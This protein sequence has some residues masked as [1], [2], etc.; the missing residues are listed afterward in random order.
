[1][2]AVLFFLRLTIIWIIRIRIRTCALIAGLLF[3]VLLLFSL[4]L[5]DDGEKSGFIFLHI[6]DVGSC[7]PNS[8]MEILLSQAI[9]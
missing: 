9:Y 4:F 6:M 7:E 2:Y 1:M 3:L 8:D 5:Q